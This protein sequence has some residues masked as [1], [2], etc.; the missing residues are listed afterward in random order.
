[1]WIGALAERIREDRLIVEDLQTVMQLYQ[2]DGRFGGKRLAE[3]LGVAI[4]LENY[5]TTFTA[6]STVVRWGGSK[7]KPS[8]KTTMLS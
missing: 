5:S 4:Q 6:P 8:A 1:M 2:L 7:P 3:A